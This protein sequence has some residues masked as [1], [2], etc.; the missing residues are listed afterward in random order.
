MF[1]IPF[2]E[3]TF[4][5]D[6]LLTGTNPAALAI[7]NWNPQGSNQSS[8][9]GSTVVTSDFTVNIGTST[10]FGSD[11]SIALDRHNLVLIAGSGGGQSTPKHRVHRCNNQFSWVMTC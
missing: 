6:G 1:F 3:L 5:T 11:F 4:G 8:T 2:Y 10:Q 9:N 7:D